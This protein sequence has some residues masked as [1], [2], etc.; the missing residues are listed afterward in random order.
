MSEFDAL[1]FS[2]TNRKS[3]GIFNGHVRAILKMIIE[4]AEE[5]SKY[6]PITLSKVDDVDVWNG[7]KARTDPIESIDT[8]EKFT[9][10][11]F[12]CTDTETYEEYY[13]IPT[14]NRPGIDADL[15]G[16]LMKSANR[17]K[18]PNHEECNKNECK[19]VRNFRDFDFPNCYGKT[20]SGI[21]QKWHLRREK[22]SFS[23]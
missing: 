15:M 7:I 2:E 19:K 12:R 4:K 20:W 16:N 13:G 5:S 3:W 9:Q 10:L 6:I 1:V 22:G 11:L 18:L 23:G 14:K 21:D 8:S 17:I